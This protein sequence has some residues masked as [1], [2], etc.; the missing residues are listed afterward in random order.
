MH[1]F[2]EFLRQI[3]DPPA[4][5]R[6]VAFW[7]L[8]HR[9]EAG[10][11]TRQVRAMARKG[12]GGFMVHARDG[13]RTGYLKEDWAEALRIVIKAA[14]QQ[15]LQVWLYDEN[16]YPS[17]PA[18]DNLAFRFPDRTMKSLA[19]RHE[20]I[21]APGATWDPSVPNCRGLN[22][23]MAASLEK[24]QTRDLSVLLSQGRKSWRVPKS[25]GRTLVLALEE[26]P[27][28]AN[29][30]G[31]FSFFP[32]YFDPDLTDDFIR[33][34]HQWYFDRFKKH[35]GRTIRGI[36]SDNSC[37]NFGHIRRAVPWGKDFERRFKAATGLNLRDLLPGVF[38]SSVPNA[39]L[40][41]LIFWQFVGRTYLE[42]YFNKI[43]TFCDRAGIISTGHLC[44]EDGMGEHARQIGD[45]FEVMR[46]FSLTAVDQLGPE[47]AGAPLLES[48]G[49]NLPAC[50]KNTA[51]AARFQGSPRIMCESFGLAG[52][53]WA[54][55]LFEVRRISG[56]L[57]AVGA[58]LIVPHGLYYSIAGGRKWEC[59]PDHFH[60]PLWSYYRSW[61]DWMARLSLAA[62]GGINLAEVAV[63]Y[64]IHS[65]RAALE[66]GQDTKTADSGTVAPDQ[67]FFWHGKWPFP[68]RIFP[69]RGTT[70]NFIEAT[71][72][73]TVEALLHEHIDFEVVDEEILNRADKIHNGGFQLPSPGRSKGRPFK[74][75]VLPAIT[76]L[77]KR[78]QSMLKKMIQAGI[79]IILL[80]ARPLA[81]FDP[82]L[83]KLEPCSLFNSYLKPVSSSRLSEFWT[84]ASSHENISALGIKPVCSNNAGRK[85]LAAQ[86]TSKITRSIL[87][88]G[89]AGESGHIV[90]RAWE[91]NGLRFY[92]LFNSSV[93]AV[94]GKVSISERSP[95]AQ[96]DLDSGKVKAWPKHEFD[97]IFEPA[98]ALLLVAGLHAHKSLN[99]GTAR[100]KARTMTIPL[101]E[102][103]NFSVAGNSLPLRQWQVQVNGPTQVYTT[104]FNSRF[105]LSSAR[106][107]MDQERSTP[108][109]ESK[110][111]APQR[112]QCFLNGAKICN[113]QPGTHLDHN[114]YEAVLP[115]GLIRQGKNIL[116][117]RTQACLAEWE[118][119][120]WPPVISGA[121]KVVFAGGRPLLDAPATTLRTGSWV[122][123][124]YPFFA[125]EGRYSQQVRLPVLRPPEKLYLNLGN[126]AHACRINFDG[127]AGG[128]RIA[129]PWR[130]D[131]TAWAG[132]AG[133][134]EIYAANTPHNLFMESARPAGLIGPVSLEKFDG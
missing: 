127:R 122:E 63:L 132:K 16:H 105:D 120:L 133:K 86:V 94:P 134:L 9:L 44:L 102:S 25:W 98:Q 36:F 75:I 99:V 2:P 35:F 77:E 21:L 39:G 37:A 97:W 119:R 13:L 131:I 91:K 57:A 124:G 112:L 67:G 60:N 110:T 114:I 52:G 27:W 115:P 50:I 83:G 89:N 66:V 84:I 28:S 72:L 23:A 29:P 51:S 85:G 6:P 116:E 64:P 54:L 128:T 88:A 12:L 7:F 34:T 61:T 46:S 109:L 74:V 18:G 55:D 100:R 82:D 22:M 104:S 1:N 31:K 125:G 17:G 14:E 33:L 79:R 101:A 111:Y 76:V 126:V 41:R 130:F 62:A 107:L 93:Q 56:W 47:Q 42:S 20:E 73:W 113:F 26:K 123:Q 65:L 53:P 68:G 4:A 45:Y 30:A 19:I 96:I 95:L 3:K 71:F 15:G 129:P 8:N 49:E 87:I 90:T 5:F 81:L 70:T 59:T 103:W 10:E 69:D 40:A 24:P 43:R 48:Y 32:D 58:D 78:T 108:E 121:F 106:L 80:N 118:Y 38:C 11:L 117:I 92:L